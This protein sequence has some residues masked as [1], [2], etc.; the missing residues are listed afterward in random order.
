[1]IYAPGFIG[2]NA[3]ILKQGSA[4]DFDEW[5]DLA[6]TEDAANR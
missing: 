1:M 5:F 6:Q 3:R 4:L 2:S